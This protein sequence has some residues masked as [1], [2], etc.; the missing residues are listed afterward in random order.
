MSI[1]QEQVTGVILAGGQ[2]SRMGGLDKG[3]IEWQGRPLI[4]HLITAF[5]TQLS[6]LVINANRNQA[7]YQSYGFPVISDQTPEHQG[8]LAGLTAAMHTVKT[9]Y[10]LTIPCDSFY[11]A[12]DFAARMLQALNTFNADLVVAHDGKQLQPTYAL[13]SVALLPNLEAFLARGERQLRA[14]YQ[15]QRMATVNCSDIAIMFQNI[16]TPAH[17]QALQEGRL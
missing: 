11:L 5:Q 16:N 3:L 15:Q 13:V 7:I 10:I 17:Y 4:E 2:G 12:P 14:W 8:P 1:K 6:S 9:P